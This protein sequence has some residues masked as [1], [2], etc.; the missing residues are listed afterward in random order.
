MT[1]AMNRMVQD[2]AL[3]NKLRANAK[4]SVTHL[5][6]EKIANEWQSLIEEI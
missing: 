3:Y 5:S 2:N 1:D 4:N 6:M